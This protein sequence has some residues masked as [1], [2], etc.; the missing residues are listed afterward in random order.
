MKKIE[1]LRETRLVA[2]IIFS[3]D[4]DPDPEA[5]AEALRKAGYQSSNAG[6]V[7]SPAGA[8]TR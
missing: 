8:P 1:A 5:A 6:R 3:G 2:S 4:L 7:S